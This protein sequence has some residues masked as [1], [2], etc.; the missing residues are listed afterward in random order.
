V[1]TTSLNFGQRASLC[2]RQGVQTPRSHTTVA[3]SC[4]FRSAEMN[5]GTPGH[6]RYGRHPQ[7]SIASTQFGL[8]PL[9]PFWGNHN[10]AQLSLPPPGATRDSARLFGV[11]HDR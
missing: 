6:R 2:S 9:R 7:R 5:G 10:P 11:I 4:R 1:W 8:A 3:S